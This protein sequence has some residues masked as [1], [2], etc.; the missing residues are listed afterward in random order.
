MGYLTEKE[1]FE[2]FN[3]YTSLLEDQLRSGDD[4]EDLI[5]EIP[6]F[7]IVSYP[8]KI[9]IV[10]TNKELET[11][12]G[13]PLE[14]IREDCQNYLQDIVHPESLRNVRKFLPEFYAG[15]HSTQ[16]LAFVQYAQFYGTTEYA[17]LITFTK[18]P[19][20]PDDLVTRLAVQPNELGAVANKMNRIVKMD[21]FKLQHFK[22]F[23]QLSKRELEVMQLLANGCNNPAIADKLFLSRQTVETHRKNIKAKLALRSFHDLMKYALAFDLV[24]I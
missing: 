1:L 10:H 7:V 17:P 16:T 6:T 4:I 8:H 2:R 15:N 20:S 14:A 21:E 11:L 9:E 3:Y 19:R 12:T 23:Q 5:N 18:A 22:R 13:Y 24:V